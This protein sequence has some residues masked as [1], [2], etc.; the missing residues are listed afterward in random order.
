MARFSW[1]MQIVDK[2]IIGRLNT[3]LSS[4]VLAIKAAM[5]G[6]IASAVLF[7]GTGWGLWLLFVLSLLSAFLV[8]LTVPYLRTGI[9]T[10]EP[11]I[12]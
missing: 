8:I 7:G 9:Y 4:I 3:T 1:M 12:E 6:V 2:S 11:C 10:D 5:T